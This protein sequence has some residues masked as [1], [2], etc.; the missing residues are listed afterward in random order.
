[1]KKNFKILIMI[2]ICFVLSLT[3]LSGCADVMDQ[4]TCAHEFELVLKVESTCAQE[5]KEVLECSLCGKTKTTKFDRLEH[6]FKKIE[7]VE[8]TCLSG[9]YILRKC[10]ECKE[11]IKTDQTDALP[12]DYDSKVVIPTCIDKGYTYKKC[13][14]CGHVEEDN[15]VDALGHKFGNWE[16]TM[17]PTELSEGLKERKCSRC[18][19]VEKKYI[20]ANTYIDL[21]YIKEPFDSNTVYECNNYEELSFRFN[22]AVANLANNVTCDIYEVSDFNTLLNDLVN[23]CDLPYSFSLSASLKGK[24][25]TI[26]FEYVGNPIYKTSGTTYKQFASLNYQHKDSSRSDDFDD[27]KI[28][29]SI[30]SFNVTTTDS[31]FYALERGAKPIIEEG[32]AS[33]VVYEEIKDVLREIIDDD[34]SDTEK[35]KAIYDWLV[36]NVVYD[37][38][39]LDLLYANTPNLNR[40]NGFYLEGVFLDKKAVC[41]GISKAFTVMCNMEGIR[42]VTVE[43]YQTKNP[44]GAGHEWNKVYIDGNWYIV[45]ATSGGTIIADEF[46]V[47]TYEYLLTSEEKYQ[48]HYTGETYTE[49]KCKNEIDIYSLM[50]FEYENITYDYVVKSQQELNKIV[51]Y[52]YSVNVSN[53]SIEFRPTFDYGDSLLDEIEEAFKENSIYTSYSYIEHECSFM[54]IRK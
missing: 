8:A 39:L 13:N 36:M 7:E 43:G 48:E 19:L 28:N 9:G 42:C 50:E 24:E 20:S 46:E 52:L 45:D 34:M 5:G 10:S 16:T 40:Y 32:S 17:E 21:S 47:L 33:E 49:L 3:V 44:S 51:D 18:D 29:K 2:F 15:Y 1:M 35:V 26:T 22:C 41:E 37:G 27:F 14:V 38:D 4:L 12:H 11:E 23:D 54:L 6:K 53:I 30:Y 25:L 31:L